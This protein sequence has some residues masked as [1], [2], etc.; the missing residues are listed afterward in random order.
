[1]SKILFAFLCIVLFACDGQNEDELNQ[2]GTVVN[3][4]SCG[5]GLEP[6]FIIKLSEKDSIMTSTLPKE[7]QKANLKI[8]F[9]TKESTLY[10]Y[11]TT[12]KIYPK[13]FDVYD[14][15]SL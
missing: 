4:T 2:T 10:V 12:D 7:F 11:C 6:V 14:V 8:Q 1:M 15:I 5:G 3:Q 9:K 13:Q